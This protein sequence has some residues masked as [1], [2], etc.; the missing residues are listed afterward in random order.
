M[1]R[2]T[3]SPASIKLLTA[4]HH[5]AVA[6]RNRIYAAIEALPC[7]KAQS[8]AESLTIWP[9]E[10][11]PIYA[12]ARIKTK[13]PAELRAKAQL[14]TDDFSCLANRALLTS[15]VADARQMARSASPATKHIP[16]TLAKATSRKPAHGKISA[17]I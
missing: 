2:K 13:T 17:R 3:K 12:A 15:I 9:D 1:S 4:Q 14:A 16:G 5:A 7:I 6:E 10:T 8:A 11:A